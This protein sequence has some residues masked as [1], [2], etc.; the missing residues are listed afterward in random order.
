VPAKLGG[1]PFLAGG[2]TL[3]ADVWSAPG[4]D[5]EVRFQFAIHSCHGCHGELFGT[6][7]YL[8]AHI[9]PRIFDVEPEIGGYLTGTTLVDPVTS[10]ARE[11]NELFR[12]AMD[13]RPLVCPEGT[14]VE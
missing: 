9:S 12:R 11:I 14:P 8:N 7:H 6:T 1:A 3:P 4:V 5:P 10:E 13:A 2:A